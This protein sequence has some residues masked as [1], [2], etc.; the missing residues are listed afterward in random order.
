VR[1]SWVP[2]EVC[3][4]DTDTDLALLKD[5]ELQYDRVGVKDWVPVAKL[6]TAV[7]DQEK[8][9]EVDTE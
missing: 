4:Q 3:V 9:G 2:V 1:V 8:V 5:T 6:V 7:G